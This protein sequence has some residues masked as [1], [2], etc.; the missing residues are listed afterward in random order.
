MATRKGREKLKIF[1]ILLDSGCSSTIIT[2][3][4]ISKLKQNKD[5]AM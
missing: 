3:N 5:V 1:L 4:P 2:E